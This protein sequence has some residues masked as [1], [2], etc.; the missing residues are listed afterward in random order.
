MEF[1]RAILTPRI[2]VGRDYVQKAQTKEQVSLTVTTQLL[3]WLIT[4][5]M[6]P[7]DWHIASW[8]NKSSII[9]MFLGTSWLFSRRNFLEVTYKKGGLKYK[10]KFSPGR[11]TIQE[12]KAV[13]PGIPPSRGVP[14]LTPCPC[15]GGGHSSRNVGVRITCF[16][17]DSGPIML[18]RGPGAGGGRHF[19][20]AFSSISYLIISSLYLIV[21]IPSVV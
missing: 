16:V 18:H 4:M 21:L 13:Y 3:E 19:Y 6:T 7:S 17:V 11:W 15:K 10:L 20:W 12:E 14:W 5:V 1:T 2:K 8:T 9:Q